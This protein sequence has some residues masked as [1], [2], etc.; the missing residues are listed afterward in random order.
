MEGGKFVSSGSYGCVNDPPVKCS[1]DTTRHKS[2]YGDSV[3]KYFTN[4]QS[5]QQEFEINEQISKIDPS[6]EWTLPL[7]KKCIITKFDTGDEPEKCHLIRQRGDTHKKYIQLIYK[8]GGDD[9]YNTIVKH[10]TT[11]ESFKRELFLKF[12]KQL[13][14][15]IKGLK[16]LNQ[17]KYA[18]LDIKP[19]N[20][21]Y[22]GKK[23]YVIDFGLLQNPE[24]LYKNPNEKYLMFQ[25]PYYPPEF[26]FYGNWIKKRRSFASLSNQFIASFKHT[27]PEYNFKTIWPNYRSDLLQFYYIV[28]YKTDGFKSKRQMQKLFIEMSE[29]IDVFSLGYTFTE[30]FYK[31]IGVSKNTMETFLI[32]MLL[33]DMI[34]LNPFERL[35]WEQLW[36]EY[37]L[38]YD[39]IYDN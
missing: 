33:D 36:K 25:Y 12:F 4:E 30:I 31:L 28:G 23:I 32:K 8:N 39:L 18:H 1:G 29:K 24:N 15:I 17:R 19:T 6:H 27:Y 3:G 5:A 37:N 34:K 13:K 2:Y 35:D 20:M 26:K 16:E 10:R 38:I 11:S 7:M 9:L 21:M 22:D 14:P